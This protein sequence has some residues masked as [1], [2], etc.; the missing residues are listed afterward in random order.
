MFQGGVF[1]AAGDVNS[2]TA[3]DT[4][5]RPGTGILKS[6]DGGRTS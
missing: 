4:S 2:D 5:S 1:V 6:T 3:L